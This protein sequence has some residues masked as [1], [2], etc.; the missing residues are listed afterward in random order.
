MLVFAYSSY[1]GRYVGYLSWSKDVMNN[2]MYV[3]NV[4]HSMEEFNET[5]EEF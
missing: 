3:L 5:I 4:I 2:T 1:F